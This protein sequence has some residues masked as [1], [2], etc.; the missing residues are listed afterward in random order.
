M[1]QDAKLTFQKRTSRW[2]LKL[3][4]R[5]LDRNGRKG[6]LSTMQRP[7]MFHLA[8]LLSISLAGGINADRSREWAAMQKAEWHIK[9]STSLQINTS[10]KDD[11]HHWNT[12][13]PDT[14]CQGFSQMRGSQTSHLM[15]SQQDRRQ[16]GAVGQDRNIGKQKQHASDFWAKWVINS[17]NFLVIKKSM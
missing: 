14:K 11:S 3:S 6:Y 8:E 1:C 9:L 15:M 2:K 17:L 13:Q 4:L 16:K 7:V 12:M 10:H 5:G